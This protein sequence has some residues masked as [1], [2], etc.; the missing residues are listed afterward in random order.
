MTANALLDPTIWTGKIFTGSWVESGKTTQTTEPATGEV[1]L[2][3]SRD[4]VARWVTRE[5]GKFRSAT[6]LELQLAIDESSRHS[7]GVATRGAAV[8]LAR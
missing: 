5:A 6:Q 2:T 3:D 4:E 8:A 1:L 7:A